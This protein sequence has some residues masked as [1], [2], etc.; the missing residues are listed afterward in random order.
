[1]IELKDLL[2]K[3]RNL[4]LHDD[5]KK[6]AIINVLSLVVGV[7]LTK[8]DIKIKDNIIYLNLKPIFK[9]EIFL[10]KEKILQ[11]L[12]NTLGAKIPRDIR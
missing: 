2:G 8:E 5:Y 4:L 3:F 6:D 9:S 12:E 7:K 1:M 11:E 10:K